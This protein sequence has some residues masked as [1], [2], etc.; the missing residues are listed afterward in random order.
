MSRILH[1]VEAAD[2]LT[3]LSVF[4]R[5]S[6]LVDDPYRLFFESVE[7]G[8]ARGRY[9]IIALLPDTI[10]RCKDGQAFRDGRPEEAA[11]LVSLKALL[12]ESRMDLPEGLP[13]MIGGV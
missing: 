11:P 8:A 13:P 7:G 5:L 9:S 10:W 1:R 2:L 4:L 12:D 3:P 6:R